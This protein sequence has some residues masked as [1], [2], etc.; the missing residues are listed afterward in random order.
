MKFFKF[1][2][3]EQKIDIKWFFFL[4]TCAIF[5][6]LIN[7][8]NLALRDWDEGYYGTV[9]KDMFRTGN[10]LY[11]TYMD[12]PFFFKPPLLIWLINISYHLGG[13]SEWTTRLPCALITASGVPLLYLIGREIFA[14]R[15]SAV[16]SAMVYLTLLPVI[17]HGRLAMI[18]GIINT[19]LLIAIL[20]LLK[21]RQQP[22]WA[23]GVGIGLGLIALSKGT[24]VIALGGILSVFMLTDKPGKWLRNPNLWLGIILGFLP[25]VIWYSAQVQH[26]GESFIQVHFLEQNFG[27]L[28]TAVEGNSGAVWYY[29]LELAKYSFPWLIFLPGGMI[30][31]W[32]Q[33]R[34]TWAKLVL[35]GIIIFMGIISVMQTKLPWYI[36]PLYPFFALAVG[37]Y[38]AQFWRGE[39]TA[40]P[41]WISILLAICG[42]AAIVGGGYL[43]ITK[44]ETVLVCSVLI[45]AATLLLAAWKITPF[46]SIPILF[47]GLYLSL[48]MLMISHTW[49][50]ELNESF[51]VKP[52]ATL[53]RENIPTET[54]VYTSFAYRRPSLD[55]YSDRPVIPKTKEELQQL[56][57]PPSYLLLERETLNDLHLNNS[58]VL[59]TVDNFI[60]INF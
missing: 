57:L 22:R 42:L 21:A 47:T 45:V 26:Y 36:M 3:K 6:W 23:L 18:D 54:V 14:Q 51:P 33:R 55:F 50:W 38:L 46:Y 11:L 13:I 25:A 31:A 17:R 32:Q 59:G 2:S 19:F 56:T 9:A 43:L 35:T 28:A 15:S 20:C 53:I 37:A 34:Q 41:K 52:I 10:W 7:L 58:R 4:F 44:A 12:E 30:L 8:G 48:T 16:C 49:I 39:K 29:L 27:R 5:L 24:L 60:L 1:L 40:Y